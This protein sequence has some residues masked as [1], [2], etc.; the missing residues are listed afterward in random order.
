ML[1]E[2][3]EVASQVD[4]LCDV[5]IGVLVICCVLDAVDEL[6]KV[7]ISDRELF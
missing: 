2:V 6:Y 5:V 3:V 4:H 7:L 1:D